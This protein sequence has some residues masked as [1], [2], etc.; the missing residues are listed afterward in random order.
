M[1]ILKIKPEKF[2][3]KFKKTI[4][5]IHNEKIIR[6]AKRAP[7]NEGSFFVDDKG[8]VLFVTS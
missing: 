5:R 7:A 2:N 1:D 8:T 3:K 6:Q 4:Q